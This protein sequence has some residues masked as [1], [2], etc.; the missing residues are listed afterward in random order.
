MHDDFKENLNKRTQLEQKVKN[1]QPLNINDFQFLAENSIDPKIL[2]AIA[3]KLIEFKSGEITTD[4]AIAINLLMKNKRTTESTK[5]KLQAFLEKHEQIALSPTRYNPT[6]FGSVN[7]DPSPAQSPK[8]SP[9]KRSPRSPDDVGFLGT[10]YNKYAAANNQN[11]GTLDGMFTP[12][13]SEDSQEKQGCFC[14]LM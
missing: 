9:T 14:P 13:S 8:N 4:V 1:K 7:Q 10:G 11:L 5:G 12:V 2:S 6:I 3:K